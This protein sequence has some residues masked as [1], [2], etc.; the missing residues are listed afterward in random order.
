[1]RIGYARVSTDDQNLEAHGLVHLRHH[2]REVAGDSPCRQR[3]AAMERGFASFHL[4]P[5]ILT[6]P[7]FFIA[8]SVKDIVR[9]P[10]SRP[11]A[12]ICPAISAAGR[13][14]CWVKTSAIAAPTVWP[15]PAAP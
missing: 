2:D 4:P 11:A 6:R 3:R 10:I 1:M 15:A 14:P 12:L 7:R 9:L 8:C 5:P 13:A